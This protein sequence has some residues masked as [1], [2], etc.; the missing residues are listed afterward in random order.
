MVNIPS[1]NHLDNIAPRGSF[2]RLQTQNRL[3]FRTRGS[4]YRAAPANPSAV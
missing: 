3:S 1:H 2:D 4:L